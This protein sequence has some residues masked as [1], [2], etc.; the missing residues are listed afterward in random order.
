MVFALALVACE[1]AAEDTVEELGP[2][3]RTWVATIARSPARFT[4]AIADDRAGW[5]MVHNHDLVRLEGNGSTAGRRGAAARAALHDDLARIEAEAWQRLG[6]RWE[7]RS[8]LPEGSALPFFVGLA[9]WDAGDQETA[10]GWLHRAS[11]ADDDDIRGAALALAGTPPGNAPSPDGNFWLQRVQAHIDGRGNGDAGDLGDGASSP[12]LREHADGHERLFH[13]PMAHRTLAT[14]H[15]AAAGTVEGLAAVLFS[16]C[17][18]LD[19]Q[20]ACDAASVWQPL[21][22]SLE[23]GDADEAEAARSWVRALDA[24]LDPWAKRLHDEVSDEGRELLLQLRLVPGFRAQ[25]LLDRARQAL[26]AGHPRQAQAYA[27][28]ALDLEHPREVSPVNAP[29]LYAAL[30]EAN[31]RTGHTREALDAL[32]VLTDLLPTVAGVDELVGDLAV[33]EGLDRQG[34]SKEN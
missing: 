2:L 25:V 11:G 33:L 24:K 20:G 13:D 18:A 19:D 17:P 5:V 12:V 34:D 27:Q 4:D 32:Q 15:R 14:A 9:A 10:R 7:A 3:D 31:L 1:N 8:G 30:A 28:L 22:L 21:G 23:A 26:R 6:K 16:P 29:G